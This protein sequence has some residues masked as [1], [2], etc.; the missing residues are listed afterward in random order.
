MSKAKI[1]KTKSKGH[2]LDDL[3]QEVN[4]FLNFL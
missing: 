2:D 3:K 4:L 1:P